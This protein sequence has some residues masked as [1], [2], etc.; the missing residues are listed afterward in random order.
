MTAGRNDGRNAVGEQNILMPLI[1]RI[2]GKGLDA[3]LYPV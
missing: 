3:F 1:R 2:L